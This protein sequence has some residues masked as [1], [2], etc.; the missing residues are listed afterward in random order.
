MERVDQIIRKYEKSGKR[1]YVDF[2]TRYFTSLEPKTLLEI[3]VYKGDSLRTWKEVFPKATIY[4]IDID[5]ST[6]TISP[7]LSIFIGDQTDHKFLD[8]VLSK[9]GI[10]DIIIDDGGHKRSQ[11]IGSLAYL[12]PKLRSGAVYVIEDLQVN[13]KQP[14][15]D[16]KMSAI[17]YLKTL[18]GPDGNPQILNYSTLIFEPSICL[19]VKA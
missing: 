4:G 7:E 6:K 9:I 12:F 3:G 14:W 13:N 16:Y 8:S 2:Y 19:L 18:I 11:Q 17:D 1:K 5:P 15:N 10:P